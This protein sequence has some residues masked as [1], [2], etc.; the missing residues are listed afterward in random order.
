[1]MDLRPLTLSSI[2]DSV[3]DDADVLTFMAAVSEQYTA[4]Y[5]DHSDAEIAR[6]G[7]HLEH[8][9]KQMFLETVTVCLVSGNTVRLKT[10]TRNSE[11]IWAL[12]EPPAPP[13][14]NIIFDC[15]V[16]AGGPNAT[17]SSITPAFNCRIYIHMDSERHSVVRPENWAGEEVYDLKIR[18]QEMRRGSWVTPDR[19]GLEV[20]SYQLSV[21]DSTVASFPSEA[22]T[23]WT[24]N[25]AES[26]RCLEQAFKE[27]GGVAESRSSIYV[28]V[29]DERIAGNGDLLGNGFHQFMLD[30][31]APGIPTTSK[32]IL[33]IPTGASTAY[34]VGYIP[35]YLQFRSYD[36]ALCAGFLKLM[37]QY[38][39][40]HSK[41]LDDTMQ[42]V[43]EEITQE[44]SLAALIGGSSASAA[45]VQT[46]IGKYHDR[47]VRLQGD[48]AEK[49]ETLF[50]LIE[51]NKACTSR[52]LVGNDEF[53]KMQTMHEGIKKALDTARG[54]H[55]LMAHSGKAF[56]CGM[57][58]PRGL[59]VPPAVTAM[60]LAADG[61]ILEFTFDTP[62]QEF[63]IVS[64][65]HGSVRMTYFTPGTMFARAEFLPAKNSTG[66]ANVTVTLRGMPS[67][68][69][70][71]TTTMHNI[72]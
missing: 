13:A 34:F 40:G 18:M 43:L 38:E 61:R 60:K 6:H 68:G 33:S 10:L 52:F 30:G 49:L 69:S 21:L 45:Q 23:R 59:W 28:W 7:M 3:L 58:A 15:H 2:D 12:G 9:Y 31:E 27:L 32:P 1:M 20:T 14:S 37:D 54:F 70:M 66:G 16:A 72:R 44:R 4:F 39:S 62:V 8:S 67:R 35:A 25:A 22:P 64:C 47:I 42:R 48:M 19:F 63:T 46:F 17:V 56:N 53:Y 55:D 51:R 57:T 71:K 41:S 24:L 11:G 5:N 36:P 26:K 29:Q 50:D 65:D